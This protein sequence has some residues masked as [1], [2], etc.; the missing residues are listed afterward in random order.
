MTTRR[1]N[2][3]RLLE[4]THDAVLVLRTSVKYI[5]RAVMGLYAMVG[6]VVVGAVVAHALGK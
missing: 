6:S 1:K 4:E 5:W 3:M 2:D